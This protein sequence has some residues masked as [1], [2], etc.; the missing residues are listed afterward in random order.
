MSATMYKYL[1]SP[2]RKGWDVTTKPL[3]DAVEEHMKDGWELV[4]NGGT[5]LEA[6]TISQR[7]RVTMFKESPKVTLWP[8]V[9]WQRVY[10]N[11][12]SRNPDADFKYP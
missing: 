10:D 1:Y 2:M 9:L 7:W 4:H 8:Q 12:W 11:Y 6:C 3:I 5:W